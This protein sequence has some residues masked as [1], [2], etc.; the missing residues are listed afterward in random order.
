MA[1]RNLY[2]LAVI[3]LVAGCAPARPDPQIIKLCHA[4]AV[5]RARGITTDTS[6]IG[7][8]V[9]QCMSNRGYILRETGPNCGGDL[10]TALN[11]VCYHRNTPI[12]RFTAM[13]EH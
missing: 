3:L 11:P 7:E 1:V 10:S 6:D 12:G 5:T 9:E 13:F 8:L 2:A 4:S